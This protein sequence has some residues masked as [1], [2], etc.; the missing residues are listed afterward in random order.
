MERWHRGSVECLL[1]A[2]CN[3][4]GRV[5]TLGKMMRNERLME[6]LPGALQQIYVL[7]HSCKHPQTHARARSLRLE[8]NKRSSVNDGREEEEE[9]TGF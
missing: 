2:W 8:R 9:C 5:L 7:F 6:T 3:Y 4:T 1:Q